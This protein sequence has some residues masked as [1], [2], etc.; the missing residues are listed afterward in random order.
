MLTSVGITGIVAATHWAVRGQHLEPFSAWPRWVRS[1]S[2]WMLRPV[3]RSL[4]R[5]GRNPQDA[6]LWLLGGSV[7]FGILLLTVSRWLIGLGASFLAVSRAGP[8][9]IARFAVDL[10]IGFL[11]AALIIRVVSTWFGAGRF[12]RLT[13]WAWVLTDW[14]INP[15]RRFMPSTGAIDLSPLVG[16]LGLIL[17]RSVLTALLR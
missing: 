1:W 8:I 9:A 10:I 2:D 5:M 4:L 14:L 15:I 7:V 11:M 12:S 17:I 3:T 6:P 13:R 16:Y